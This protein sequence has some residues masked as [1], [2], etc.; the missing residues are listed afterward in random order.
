VNVAS[1]DSRIEALDITLFSHIPSQTT[2]ADKRSLLAAQACAR[3]RSDGYVYLEIGSHLGRSIQTHLQDPRC[4]KIYSI[5]K[6]PVVQ[7]DDRGPTY[8]YPDNSTERMIR[9]L[10]AI[11]PQGVSKIECFDQD[12]SSIPPSRLLL[13]PD[14]CFV[15]GEHTASAVFA[16]FDFC[17]SV[18]ARGATIVFHDAPI[19]FRGL[20]SA[21]SSLRKRRREFSSHALS[22][23][24]YVICLDASTVRTGLSR[25]VAQGR[26]DDLWSPRNDLRLLKWR[27]LTVK[28]RAS[29]L[30]TKLLGRS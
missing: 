3:G 20:R 16:D 24:I 2:D 27:A 14:L 26:K 7:P 15:D 21:V 10:T 17:L 30:A 1:F 19:V 9:L 6:R 23:A 22:D 25:F 4:K 5:D 29:N 8:E 12:A 18:C 11:D 13:P 28:R